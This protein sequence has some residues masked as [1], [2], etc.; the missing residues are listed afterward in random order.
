MVQNRVQYDAML[1]EII[2]TVV[3]QTA[4]AN[5]SSLIPIVNAMFA[6]GN[7]IVHHAAANQKY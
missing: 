2:E 5:K 7:V 6:V 4:N 3:Y 1:I